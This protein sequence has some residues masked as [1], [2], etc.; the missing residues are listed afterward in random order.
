MWIRHVNA[1]DVD[2]SSAGLWIAEPFADPAKSESVKRVENSDIEEEETPTGFAPSVIKTGR[3]ILNSNWL[4][5][6]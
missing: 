4:T 1:D 6:I 5:E 2:P 3:T